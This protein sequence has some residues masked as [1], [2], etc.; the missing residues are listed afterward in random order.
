[1]KLRKFLMSMTI[2]FALFAA[3]GVMFSAVVAA[4]PVQDSVP[5]LL[6]VTGQNAVCGMCGD[7]VCVPQC[8]E[9]RFT[10]PEDC[11]LEDRARLAMVCGM[12]GDGFCVPQ[13]GENAETCPQDCGVEEY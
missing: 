4:E 13:C 6:N 9:N 2:L 5:E 3:S 10:C 8:G 7:G 12:C 11:G 1:M